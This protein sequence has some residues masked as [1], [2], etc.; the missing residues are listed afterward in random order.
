MA[1]ER[2]EAEAVVSTAREGMR[3]VVQVPRCV[4]AFLCCPRPRFISSSAPRALV[5]LVEP[6][7]IQSP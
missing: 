5:D 2:T 1:T 3:D 4:P 6:H 7:G